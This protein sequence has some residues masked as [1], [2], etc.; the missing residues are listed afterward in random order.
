MLTPHSG[1]LERLLEKQTLESY[2]SG[3]A[4]ILV[5]KG[6]HPQV[7]SKASR[8][9]LFSGSAVLARGG[10]G[11]LLTGI[12]GSLL[13]RGGRTLEESVALGVCGMV[14]LPKLWL[15]RMGR[16]QLASCRF[17]IFYPSLCVMISEKTHLPYLF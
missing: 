9:H 15:D 2:L 5:K 10:S 3:F 8:L 11:D 6:P 16:K 17:W 12:I 1:E 13:A 7:L 14:V 4:G